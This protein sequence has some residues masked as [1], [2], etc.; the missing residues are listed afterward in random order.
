MPQRKYRHFPKPEGEAR[1]QP[2]PAGEHDGFVA[3]PVHR[4]H[5]NLWAFAESPTEI[6]DSAVTLY[7]VWLR[8]ILPLVCSGALWVLIFWVLGY[9]R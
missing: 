7:P 9:L 1:N 2:R 6:R 3:S 5:Q 8:L 4:M